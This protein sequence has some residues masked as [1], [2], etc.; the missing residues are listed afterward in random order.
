MAIEEHAKTTKEE[1]DPFTSEEKI[2]RG[3]KPLEKFKNA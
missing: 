1:L 3:R 2:L